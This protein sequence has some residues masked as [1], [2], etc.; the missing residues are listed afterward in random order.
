MPNWKSFGVFEAI[1][2]YFRPDV[3]LVTSK[4]GFVAAARQETQEK[5]AQPDNRIFRAKSHPILERLAWK[6]AT[7]R[8]ASKR[9]EVY[10]ASA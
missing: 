10:Y 7:H 1:I 4:Y 5:F 9:M 2:S 3:L 6:S 8:A